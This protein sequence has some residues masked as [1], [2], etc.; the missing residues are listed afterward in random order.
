MGK[1][2][3]KKNSLSSQVFETLGQPDKG[4]LPLYD[5]GDFVFLI[6]SEFPEICPVAHV[7]VYEASNR[8]LVSF[9]HDTSPYIAANITKILS[10]FDPDIMYSHCFNDKGKPI[11]INKE[12]GNNWK[13]HLAFDG[14]NINP[15]A[16]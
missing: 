3:L 1:E 14:F 13:K 16:D 12:R 10:D 2:K 6:R 11:P 15:L 7:S 4:L 8:I 5:K 9:Y